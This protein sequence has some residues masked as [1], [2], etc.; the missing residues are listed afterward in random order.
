MPLKYA[1]EEYRG[2][3]R[4]ILGLL[5]DLNK[6]SD[7]SVFISGFMDTGELF[8][9]LGLTADEAY[10]FL[11][12]VP[13]YE[14]CGILCRIPNWWKHRQS[15]ALELDIRRGRS[16]LGAKALLR[17]DPGITVDGV[18]M[19]EE[20]IL[21]LLRMSEGLAFLK[22]KW[23][24]VNHSRLRNLLDRYRR[25]KEEYGE[26]MTFADAFRMSI[27]MDREDSDEDSGISNSRWIAEV[28]ANHPKGIGAL[29]IPDTFKGTLRPYQ[30]KGV[31]WVAE[32]SDLG[33]GACLADDMGLGKTAQLLAFLESRRGPGDRDLL[34]V[35][36]SLI[37]N[38]QKEIAKF[39]PGLDYAVYSGSKDDITDSTLTITTYGLVARNEAFRKVKWDNIILDEAQAIKNPNTKQ[40]KSIRSL[41]GR[42]RIAMTGTPVENR[43]QDLWSIFDFINPGLLGTKDEFDRLAARMESNNSYGRLRGAV[44]PFILRR[45]KTD[46][47]IISD[48]PDKLE[49]TQM[50][51][52]SKRQKALY[53]EVLDGFAEDL[54]NSPSSSRLG[55]ILSVMTKLK[56][57]CNHPS[58]YLGQ[59]EFAESDS[60]K[61][62][63]LREICESIAEKREKVLVFTQYKE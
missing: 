41:D 2:D 51:T 23:V 19:S 40:S 29:K 56:Q 39:T 49:T 38:W 58:Q 37:S 50:I 34:I 17:C 21:E 20:E 10:T 31:R 4:K 62:G 18:R 13:L 28:L 36:A 53:R 12:E 5:S 47:S 7:R 45:M 32:L 14:E 63:M 54:E 55:L 30:D 35:P 48:L 24:E 44:A 26:G 3:S 42:F 8:H 52:L 16:F 59:K 57:V 61:F 25:I 60:G 33:F 15:T 27:G 43:L 6:V 22:G 11:T 46:K 1:L 9:P